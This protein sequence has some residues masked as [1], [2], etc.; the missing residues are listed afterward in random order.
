MLFHR[1]RQL[2][3]LQKGVVEKVAYQ[4]GGAGRYVVIRHGREYQTVYMH[5]SRALVSAGQTVKKGER[6]ALT[7]IRVFQPVHTCITSSYQ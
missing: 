5:L 7:V 1:V 3:R 2:L 6:I 4:A